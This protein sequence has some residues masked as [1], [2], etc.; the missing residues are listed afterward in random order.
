MPKPSLQGRKQGGV[1]EEW[2]RRGGGVVEEWWSSCVPQRHVV[3]NACREARG[4]RRPS[5]P[6][7]RVGHGQLLQGRMQSADE[8]GKRQTFEPLHKGMRARGRAA[9]RSRSPG[10]LPMV[11]A[12]GRHAR[13][14]QH[15]RQMSL[16]DSNSLR[17]G[18]TGGTGKGQT[19]RRAEAEG[20]PSTSAKRE[21]REGRVL[22]RPTNVSPGQLVV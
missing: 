1:V 3:R 16:H 13:R 11:A 8:C 15:M 7:G 21:E 4:R 5:R 14:S 18:A 6:E 10:P 9:R 20:H 19:R 17:R 12:R 22:R 2:W